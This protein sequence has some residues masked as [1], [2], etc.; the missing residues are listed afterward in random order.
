MTRRAVVSVVVIVVASALALVANLFAGN[1]PS[2]GL[3]LQGG[4]SV[5]LEPA[6]DDVDPVA[7]DVAVEIIRA[8][9]DSIG[10]AEPE[11]IRQGDTVVVNLPGVDDQQRALDTVGRQGEVLLRPVLQSGV[12]PDGEAFAD[13]DPFDPGVTALLPDSNGIG[14]LVGPARATGAVFSNDARAEIF[15]G[16]WVVTVGLRAGAEGEGAWNALTTLCFGRDES[17]PTGQIAIVLD[18]EV[19]SAPVVQEAVFTGGSVQITGDFSEAEA[20]DLARILE[21]GAVPVRFEVATVQTVSP[22]L[23]QDSLRAA[24]VAGLVGVLLIVL[25]FFAYYRLLAFVAA[26]GLVLS[27]ALLWSLVGLLSRTNGLALTLSGIA[28]IVVSIGLAVD[29]YVVVF[30]RIRDELRAGRSMRAVARR[31]F[32]QAMRTIFSAA[33]ATFIG[34]I[35]LW[36]LTVGSVRGFAF[37]L[38]VSTVISVVTTYWFTGPLLYLLSRTERFGGRAILGVR[39]VEE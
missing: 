27:G 25:F 10:V 26:L 38:A 22:T 20:R 18:G 1:V 23:G 30:E 36:W 29:S 17:C 24:V 32:D 19:I 33:V 9:V 21:F 7:L 34:A 28:G 31:A 6:E 14:F 15:T 37:F 39:V 16:S 3:D 5:T 4:A 2:L 8:R 11:I 35:I 13:V 12:A